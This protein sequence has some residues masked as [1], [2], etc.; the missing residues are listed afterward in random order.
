MKYASIITLN[1]VGATISCQGLQ[2]C[3]VS[4]TVPLASCF[5]R[6]TGAQLNSFYSIK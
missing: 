5:I 3:P 6:P 2:Q 4:K 1:Y